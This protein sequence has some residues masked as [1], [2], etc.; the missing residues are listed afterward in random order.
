[1][2]FDLNRWRFRLL[3]SMQ[4]FII[5]PLSQHEKVVLGLPLFV[6]VVTA[7]RAQDGDIPHALLLICYMHLS[8]QMP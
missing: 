1:M 4:H 2:T 7:V 5:E 8:C 3:A 6:L